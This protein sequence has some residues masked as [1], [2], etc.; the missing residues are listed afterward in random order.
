L[1]QP[2]RAGYHGLFITKRG[3]TQFNIPLSEKPN[4]FTKWLS[5]EFPASNFQKVS[6]SLLL[7]LLSA[8]VI[9]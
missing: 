4:G 9:N 3:Y 7:L 2:A 6:E 5:S 1:K 8:T